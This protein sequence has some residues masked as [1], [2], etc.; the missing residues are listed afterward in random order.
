LRLSYPDFEPVTTKEKRLVT[1]EFKELIKYLPLGRYPLLS[2]LKAPFYYV[3]GNDDSV[4]YIYNSYYLRI[5]DLELYIDGK[6]YAIVETPNARITIKE[7]DVRPV[8][9]FSEEELNFNVSL[10]GGGIY[11]A[12]TPNLGEFTISNKG[13]EITIFGVLCNSSSKV[14]VKNEPQR[15]ADVYLSHLPPHGVLDLAIKDGSQVIHL[16]SKVLLNAVKKYK[17]R[18]VVCGH[19]H[20]L[21]GRCEQIGNTTIINVSS[22]YSFNGYALIDTDDWALEMKTWEDKERHRRS[23]ESR[24]VQRIIST[25]RDKLKYKR[26]KMIMNNENG[27]AE[28][29]THIFNLGCFLTAETRLKFLKEIQRIGVDTTPAMEKIESLNWKK[30][31]IL[32]KITINPDKDAFIDVETGYA[33]GAEPGKLWLIG[34]WFRGDLKQFLY[35][36]KEKN[37]LNYLRQNKITSLVSWSNYDSRVLS[38]VL[39]KAG[40]CIEFFDARQRAAKCTVWHTYTLPKFHDALFPEKKTDM[41]DLIPGDIAGLY[42]DHLIISN[43]FCPYCP[44]KSKIIRQIKEKNRVDILQMVEICRKLWCS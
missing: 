23:Q 37:F 32:R 38:P 36:S 42:A 44:P 17:P 31:K 10:R 21:G 27:I 11:T 29:E 19:I 7:M 8:I 14:R 41:R 9:P 22:R 35:P 16:G 1:S 24:A 30:P 25:V 28:I 43:K 5:Q 12:I 2:K 13:E 40:L 34:V 15:Y 3:N 18:L 20:R 4:E 26:D 33:K 6:P 39:K